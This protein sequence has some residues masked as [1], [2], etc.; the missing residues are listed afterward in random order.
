VFEC[1][2]DPARLA[3]WWGPRGFSVPRIDF[4]PRVGSSY[5]ITMQPPGADTFVLAGTFREVEAPS[6][7]SFSFRW[8]PAD[9]D[10]V[11]T[12][13][14]LTFHEHDDSTEVRLVQGPFTTEERCALH[15]NGW[16]ESFDRLGELM[17]R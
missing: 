14:Q 1:F 15:R 10:D 6:R 4:D 2:V 12:V 7:L 3:T 8:E 13:A 5:R 9:A 11:E 17:S 16:I